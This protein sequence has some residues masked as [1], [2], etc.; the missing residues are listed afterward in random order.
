V[1]AFIH[2]LLRGGLEPTAQSEA[3]GRGDDLDW[4]LVLQAEASLVAGAC[5]AIGL[6]YAGTANLQARQVVSRHLTLF[7]DTK[8]STW[9]QAKAAS[10]PTPDVGLDRYTVE[11]CRAVLALSVG[12]IMA[13]T[14]DLETMVLLRS[15]RKISDH[16]TRYGVLMA[17]HT[18]LGFLFM[19]GGRWSFKRDKLSTACLLISVFP[20]FP[21]SM[22]DN[23][24]HLQAFRH[25]YVLATE[26][27]DVQ[28]VDAVTQAP[29]TVP[30]TV[31]TVERGSY[32]ATLPLLMPH[33]DSVTSLTVC[34]KRVKPVTLVKDG[35]HP[36]LPRALRVMLKDGYMDH[37]SDPAAVCSAAEHWFPAA[38]TRSLQAILCGLC[39]RLRPRGA[40]TQAEVALQD[41]WSVVGVSSED[42][43][44]NG[45]DA[46]TGDTPTAVLA[47]QLQRAAGRGRE[48]E[49]CLGQL[50]MQLLQQSLT[51]SSLRRCAQ[52]VAIL[53][54]SWRAVH[55]ASGCMS[56]QEL[57]WLQSVAED[58]LLSGHVPDALTRGWFHLTQILSAAKYLDRAVQGLDT[59][60]T[61]GD[62]LCSVAAVFLAHHRMPSI[63][64]VRRLRLKGEK[65]RVKAI[66][67]R[68]GGCSC[69]GVHALRRL[70]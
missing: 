9:S 3:G 18:A 13:G 23:Q 16:N 1:P 50:R 55:G 54:R 6:K 19:G 22:T 46:C 49:E 62:Q 68:Y 25:L 2:S 12:M 28:A 58:P 64:E 29:L 69:V 11:T 56:L 7:R 21:N 39:E 30:V 48:A 43:G 31:E 42:G 14:G 35:Q 17:I 38:S 10:L 27:R 70:V 61:T 26:E 34:C 60:C 36:A 67:D 66:R 51:S 41:L 47:L 44:A 65:L 59:A 45:V 24:C 63:G 20:R 53:V 15:L 52:T 4:L 57:C 5:L 40:S 37:A 8:F 33:R 32:Q